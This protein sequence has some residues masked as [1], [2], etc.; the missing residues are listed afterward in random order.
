MRVILDRFCIEP[1]GRGWDF[2]GHDHEQQRSPSNLPLDLKSLSEYDQFDLELEPGDCLLSYTDA[3]LEANDA[4][5]EMLG[6]IGVLRIL[7]LIGGAESQT[8]IEKLLCGN[9]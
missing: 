5:G 9:R 6:E 8:L 4:G 7:R 1:R 3:L 2:L